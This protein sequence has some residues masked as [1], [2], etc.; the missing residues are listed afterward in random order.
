MKRLNKDEKVEHWNIQCPHCLA[1][2]RYVFVTNPAMR[3]TSWPILLCRCR[4]QFIVLESQCAKH[5][6]ATGIEQNPDGFWL[7]RA[8]VIEGIR[9]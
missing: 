1:Y 4:K 9:T 7:K 3:R 6:Y 5:C 2:E 8:R